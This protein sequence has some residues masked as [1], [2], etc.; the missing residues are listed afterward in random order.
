MRKIVRKNIIEFFYF[1]FFLSQIDI[2]TFLEILSKLFQTKICIICIVSSNVA[3]LAIPIPYS[4]YA[5]YIF[6]LPSCYLSL[7]LSARFTTLKIRCEA[8][9]PSS[10]SAK[11]SGFRNSLDLFLSREGNK[12]RNSIRSYKSFFGKEKS[13]LHVEYRCCFFYERSNSLKTSFRK[14][15]RLFS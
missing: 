13:G 15:I 14:K 4:T 7:P 11:L 5:Y 2:S 8:Q 10:R 1:F 9:H 3:S 12:S 6:I